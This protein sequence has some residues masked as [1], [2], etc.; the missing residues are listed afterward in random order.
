[1]SV[2][3]FGRNNCKVKKHYL[4]LVTKTLVSKNILQ[5]FMICGRTQACQNVLSAQLLGL[6]DKKEIKN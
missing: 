4:H 3:V 6:I 1:M 5:V 2:S